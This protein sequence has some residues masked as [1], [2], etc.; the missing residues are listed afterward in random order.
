MTLIDLQMQQVLPDHNRIVLGH[1]ED[2]ELILY[3]PK[4]MKAG[5]NILVASGF[6]G[7]EIAGPWGALE[8]AKRGIESQANISFLPAANPNAVESC[9]RYNQWDEISNQGYEPGG[10]LSREG[11]ILMENLETLFHHAKDGFITVHEN[12]FYPGFFYYLLSGKPHIDLGLKL[13]GALPEGMP[14][15]DNGVYENEYEGQ[16]TVDGGCVWN[17]IDDSF[18]F[19]LHTKGVPVCVTTETPMCLEFDTR[20]QANADLIEAFVAFSGG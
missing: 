1:V 5:K 17:N 13:A 6:H 9:T 10:T 18:E 4:H 14:I 19:L 8:Y 12:P 20:V 2:Q 15:L 16:F 7:D 3:I 11:K